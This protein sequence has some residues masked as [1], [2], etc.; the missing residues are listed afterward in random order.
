MASGMGRIRS[1]WRESEGRGGTLEHAGLSGFDDAGEMAEPDIRLSARG[2]VDLFLTPL[3]P[4][5]IVRVGQ[6]E[7]GVQQGHI[8]TRL[9]HLWRTG[10]Q[11]QSDKS[12]WTPWVPRGC[13]TQLAALL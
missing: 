9:I 12:A 5:F 4:H 11:H 1:G 2:R 7:L 3:K 8:S 13:T 10:C 6:G